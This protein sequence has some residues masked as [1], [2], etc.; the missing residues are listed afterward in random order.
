MPEPSHV[1]NLTPDE[2]DGSGE[3]GIRLGLARVIKQKTTV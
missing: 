2:I 3:K 1:E